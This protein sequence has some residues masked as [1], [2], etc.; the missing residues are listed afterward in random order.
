MSEHKLGKKW[1]I[2]T[3]TV[4]FLPRVQ[5]FPGERKQQEGIVTPPILLVSTSTGR[6]IVRSVRLFSFSLVPRPHLVAVSRF[7]R[8]PYVT[9]TRQSFTNYLNKTNKDN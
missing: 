7:E 6:Q 4:Q 2:S 9:G 5:H 8:K 3:K 1:S